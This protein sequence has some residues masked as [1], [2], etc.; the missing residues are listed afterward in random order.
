MKQFNKTWFVW[1]ILV[2]IW[3]FG[4]PDVKPIFDVLVAVALFIKLTNV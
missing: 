4:F 1:L 3:N 2:T